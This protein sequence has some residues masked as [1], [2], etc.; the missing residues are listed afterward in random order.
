MNLAIKSKIFIGC[1]NIKLY[2]AAQGKPVRLHTVKTIEN[3]RLSFSECDMT[4]LSTRL[5][6]SF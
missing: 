4:G 2:F 1:E 6:F 3:L 5:V